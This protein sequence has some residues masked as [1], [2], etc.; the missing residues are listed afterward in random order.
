MS[1]RTL[2]VRGFILAL[3][4]LCLLGAGVAF[5]AHSR[6]PSSS[7]LSGLERLLAQQR[8]DEVEQRLQ[9]F[10]RRRP[11]DPQANI[12]MAQVALAR[13]DQKPELALEHL[14]QSAAP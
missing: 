2:G 4:V 13:P 5:L 11:Q 14:A 10:L 12:L 1:P 3:L 9:A 8:F 6:R 7:D